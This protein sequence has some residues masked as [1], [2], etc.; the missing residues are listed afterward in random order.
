MTLNIS[1]NR[2][3]Q[4]WNRSRVSMVALSAIAIL[5]ACTDSTPEAKKPVEV[6]GISESRS[7]PTEYVGITGRIPIEPSAVKAVLGP[8]FDLS[9]A[10]PTEI[11]FGDGMR[12]I[13]TPDPKTSAQRIIKLQVETVSEPTTRTI[14]ATPA[15]GEL[16]T[17]FV[18]AVDAA[19]TTGAEVEAAA[20]AKSQGLDT[21]V[22]QYA[23][24]EPAQLEFRMTSPNGGTLRL[25]AVD[26]PDTGPYLEITANTP[27]TSLAKGNINEPAVEGTAVE[28]IYG[29]VWFGVSRDQFE[30][31][32]DRGYGVTAGKAQ[33][34]NDFELLPHSWLRLTV[35][36]QLDDDRVD[37]AFAVVTKDGD[38]V[39][40]ARAPA[41]LVAGELFKNTVFRQIDAMDAQEARQPGSSTHWETPFY[42]DDP[43]G[44]GV[45]EV[46]AQ[47]D[48]GKARIAYAVESPKRELV[49]VDFVPYV[50]TVVVPDDWDAVDPTCAKLG[51][52]ESAVGRFDVSF[53]ASSAVLGA[54]LKAPLV[55]TVYGQIFRSEDT[56]I[57]GPIP[58]AESMATLRL[59]GVDSQEGPSASYLIDTK[60]PTGNYQILGFLD[61]DSNADPAD[62]QPDAGDPVF[63]PIGG[64]ALTCE[65]QPVTAEFALTLPADY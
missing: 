56:K 12:L 47:G 49:D 24:S 61:I 34:F 64:F 15:S 48:K 40:F 4:R 63:I 39:P 29:L 44:G 41:S 45:V 30:F 18:A 5:G 23:N 9:A 51:T 58:G 8:L 13:S 21:S 19:L 26:P 36:P 60:L 28:S 55:G 14:A 16:G 17:T 2:R 59:E 46:V 53:V 11:D 1:T 31:F 22:A 6:L 3:S 10:G 7:K 32:V 50:G 27:V 33:N 54:D 42:Y 65:R 20:L 25:A 62:P 43:E 57:T 52:K 38:R 37:V 35:T